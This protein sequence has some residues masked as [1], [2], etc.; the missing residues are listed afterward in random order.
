M[1]LDASIFEPAMEETSNGGNNPNRIV[2]M[3]LT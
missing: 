1:I 3:D 2:F